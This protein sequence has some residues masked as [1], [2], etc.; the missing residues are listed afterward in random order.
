[1]HEKEVIELLKSRDEGGV[2]QLLAHFGPLMRYVIAPILSN[3]SD[4]E[5]CLSECAMRV[6]ERIDRYDPE[7]GSWTAWLTALPFLAGIALCTALGA[8]LRRK[9]R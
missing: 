7:R 9:S 4:R 8:Y 6:W 1:M 5:E 3:E 2:A